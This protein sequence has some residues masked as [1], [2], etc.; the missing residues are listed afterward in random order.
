MGQKHT[1]NLVC[2]DSAPPDGTQRSLG[3]LPSAWSREFK[4]GLEAVHVPVSASRS[5]G[6]GSTGDKRGVSMEG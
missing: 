3:V 2:M 4:E 1:Q 6:W 5:L